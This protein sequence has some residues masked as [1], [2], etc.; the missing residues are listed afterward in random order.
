[1]E[2][3]AFDDSELIIE[4]QKYSIQYFIQSNECMRSYIE[5][6]LFLDPYGPHSNSLRKIS[7][8]AIK[9]PAARFLAETLGWAGCRGFNR[10]IH[11]HADAP[12]RF[13][14]KSSKD[15]SYSHNMYISE[16]HLE[17]T[18]GYAFCASCVKE[19]YEHL[20]YSY[21]RRT[22]GEYVSVCPK[23]NVLLAKNCPYCGEG[24]NRKG[25]NL[26]VMW[27]TCSGNHLR[28]A[29][30]TF[31]EDAQLLDQAHF[32]ESLYA[33]KYHLPMELI[34]D[35]ASRQLNNYEINNC[36]WSSRLERKLKWSREGFETNNGQSLNSDY[37]MAE[38]LIMLYGNFDNML[39]SFRRSE[40]SYRSV[41]STWGSY[42]AGG[43]ESVC[44]VEESRCGKVGIWSCPF[45]SKLSAH[46]YS[47]DGWAR[48]AR[49]VYECCH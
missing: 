40:K 15:L 7:R 38:T 22:Y 25:H 35:E 26:D 3:K 8:K 48:R 24:F 23:H 19:D 30:I 6:V 28:D 10:L 42:M 43:F 37:H 1:M 16:F 49:K 5:R 13:I 47:R 27:K 34:M 41:E 36:S 45:P 44:Y 46:P 12:L 32:Y 29:P 4:S 18:A 14:V 17:P 31:N 9:A 33:H 2:L 21:W 39:K 20:G 11:M